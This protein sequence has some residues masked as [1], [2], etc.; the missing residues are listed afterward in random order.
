[1]KRQLSAVVLAL[2][3]AA[4][5]AFAQAAHDHSHGGNVQA[6][7]AKAVVN[8]E[9]RKV[10][11]EQGKLTLAHDPI[12]NLGMPKMTMVFRVKDKTVL[13]QI[14]SGDKVKFAADRI[15]GQLTVTALQPEK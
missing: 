1:M 4:G 6:S 8:G 12:P 14:K 3:V 5:T 15:D 9:V 13:D 2:A 10:D 7:Q 11:T